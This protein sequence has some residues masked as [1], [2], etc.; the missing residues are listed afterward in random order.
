MASDSTISRSARVAS[1]LPGRAIN[2]PGAV[3]NAAPH[4]G[5]RPP[6]VPALP[7]LSFP[8]P[9]ND[10][11]LQLMGL[12][13][14]RISLLEARLAAL[15]AVVQIGPGG[16][17]T[18][19]SPAQVSVDAASVNIM[20]GAVSVDAAIVSASSVVQCQTIIADSVVGA[21]Y[22]PGAGNVW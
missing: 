14:E 4:T 12:M 18:I 3:G 2:G 17:V 13:S 19:S 1:R 20:A 5:G 8:S 9:T 21:S 15:E 11:L 7:P 10:N 22:T 6:P 16:G